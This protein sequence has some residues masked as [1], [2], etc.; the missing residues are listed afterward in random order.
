VDQ[1]EIDFLEPQPVA[2]QWVARIV[3]ART[4]FGPLKRNQ[5]PFY[6]D[7]ERRQ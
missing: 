1:G 7:E 5:I 3:A 6:A 4:D 2:T